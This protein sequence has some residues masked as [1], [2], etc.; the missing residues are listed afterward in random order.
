VVGDAKLLK[1]K[2][3][4]VVVD[5][6]GEQVVLNLTDRRANP[7]IDEVAE[8][9]GGDEAVKTKGRQRFV[10]DQWECKWESFTTID[11]LNKWLKSNG[12]KTKVFKADATDSRFF[13]CT[14]ATAKPCRQRVDAIEKL[15]AGKKTAHTAALPTWK[16]GKKGCTSYVAYTDEHDPTSV[17]Y[18]GKLIW[19][20]AE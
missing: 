11:G 12:G 19:R 16:V 8:G 13:I 15:K 10:E 14:T 17:R 3:A 4:G 5:Q 9:G 2:M 6:V 18:Y 20:I 1:G 7:I